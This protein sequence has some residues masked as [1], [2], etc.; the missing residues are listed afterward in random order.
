MTDKELKNRT[1][2][3][4]A[5]NSY[6]QEKRKRE[7]YEGKKDSIKESDKI[8]PEK[9]KPSYY[10]KSISEMT[11]EELKAFVNRMDLQSQAAKYTKKSETAG[12]WFKGQMQKAGKTLVGD[13]I[14]GAAKYGAQRLLWEV[15]KMDKAERGKGGPAR[16]GP[17]KKK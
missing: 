13:F 14:D 16:V 17:F 5:E 1:D 3:L 2:R 7:E 11:D 8:K 9:E 15:T 4:R 6:E 10:G 12:E